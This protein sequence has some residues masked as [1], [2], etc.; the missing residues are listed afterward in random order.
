MPGINE[1]S[2]K[3]LVAGDP[4]IVEYHDGSS[5]AILPGDLVYI[6]GVNTIDE[7]GV[8]TGT[9]GLAIGVAGYEQ[10]SDHY[11]PD[12]VDTAYASGA[13]IPVILS[14]SGCIVR[15]TMAAELLNVNAALTASGAGTGN[16]KSG[17]IGTNH[18][19]GI[20]MENA[21]TTFSADDLGL[22]LLL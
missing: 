8:A 9:K 17:T 4:V 3:I 11:K 1:P 14:G 12:D 15:G 18:I 13:M 20:L 2:N 16:F 5:G 10:A 22:V 6:N 7:G 19:Y 21:A